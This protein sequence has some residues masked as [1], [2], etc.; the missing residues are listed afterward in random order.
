[1]SLI[2]NR[3]YFLLQNGRCIPRIYHC[4]DD[5]DCGDDSDEA[6]CAPVTC[7]LSRF[8]VS[9]PISM[10]NMSVYC[11]CILCAIIHQFLIGI[12][13][14]FF[15]FG[16]LI[17]TLTQTQSVVCK[18]VRGELM[19]A[20][21]IHWIS[22]WIWASSR[23]IGIA[24]HLWVRQWGEYSKWVVYELAQSIYLSQHANS[25]TSVQQPTYSTIVCTHTSAFHCIVKSVI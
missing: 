4:D 10:Q 6:G 18:M 12:V 11:V 21:G 20:P 13:N 19:V 17:R 1:M 8:S 24:I 2:F 15:S 9:W 16:C 5:N 23:K 14:H 25:G 22:V 7:S 3:K